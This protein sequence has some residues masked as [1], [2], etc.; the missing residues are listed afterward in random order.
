MIEPDTLV[1]PNQPTP[2]TLAQPAPTTSEPTNYMMGNT[3]PLPSSTPAPSQY[4]I[5]ISKSSE[6]MTDATAPIESE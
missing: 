4:L 1:D 6:E 5:V 2:T 3:A